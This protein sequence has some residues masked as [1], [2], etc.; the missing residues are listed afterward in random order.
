MVTASGLFALWLR[1]H[2]H[3]ILKLVFCGYLVNQVFAV[4]VVG[5]AQGGLCKSNCLVKE[6]LFLQ[7]HFLDFEMGAQNIVKRV[8]N[9]RNALSYGI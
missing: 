4:D 6:Q 8:F 7:C 5:K 9:R 2:H 1:C 3:L